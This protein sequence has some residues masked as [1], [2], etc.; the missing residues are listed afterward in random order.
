MM[1]FQYNISTKNI[2]KKISRDTL[3]VSENLEKKEKIK[4]TI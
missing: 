4:I 1:T 2:N 3:N